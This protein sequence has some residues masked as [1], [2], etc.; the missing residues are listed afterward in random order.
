MWEGGGAAVIFLEETGSSL[1]FSSTES[2][3]GC[4]SQVGKVKS[5]PEELESGS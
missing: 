1:V 4:L 5:F 2:P 3:F